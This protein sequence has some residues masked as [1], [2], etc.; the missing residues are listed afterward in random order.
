MLKRFSTFN[1]YLVFYETFIK[2]LI[3]DQLT[4]QTSLAAVVNVM[5][6]RV[7]KSTQLSKYS[8]HTLHVRI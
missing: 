2:L 5:L 7:L 6:K 4:H 1:V 3:P 8:P